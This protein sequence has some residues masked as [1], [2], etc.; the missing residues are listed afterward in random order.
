MNS[1][2]KQRWY[3]IRTPS[4]YPTVTTC[5]KKNLPTFSNYLLWHMKFKPFIIFFFV[6]VSMQPLFQ[7]KLFCHQN[8]TTIAVKTT[9]R[10]LCKCTYDSKKKNHEKQ[11]TQ[12]VIGKIVKQV[13]P[14][15]SIASLLLPLTYC[16]VLCCSLLLTYA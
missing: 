11:H 8:I 16:F 3:L 2:S 10:R 15:F 1:P 13:Y 7:K 12:H 14:V 6:L 9:C 4:Q 5:F